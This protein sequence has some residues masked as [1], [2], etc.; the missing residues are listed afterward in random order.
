M[1]VKNGLSSKLL[2][3]VLSIFGI[4]VVTLVLGS[5][6]FTWLVDNSQTQE[7]V[8]WREKHEQDHRQSIQDAKAEIKQEVRELKEQLN[9]S[10]DEMKDMLE[11]IIRLQ[12]QSRRNTR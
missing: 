7:K 3:F 9:R 1:E 12:E 11:K 6:G 2:D 8:Q 4:I 5:Y 10:Q